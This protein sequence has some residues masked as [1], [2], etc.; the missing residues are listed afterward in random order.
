MQYAVCPMVYQVVFVRYLDIFASEPCRNFGLQDCGNHRSIRSMIH[1]TFGLTLGI[2][3]HEEQKAT[4]RMRHL[5][6]ADSDSACQSVK[7][8]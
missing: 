8:T 3:K 5:T 1:G 6:W 2:C 4:K 7:K